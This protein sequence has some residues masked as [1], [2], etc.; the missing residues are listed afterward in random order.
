[1]TATIARALEQPLNLASAVEAAIASETRHALTL[2]LSAVMVLLYGASAPAMN[3]PLNVIAGLVLLFPMLLKQPLLWWTLVIAL[4]AGNAA[5]WYF[6]DNHKYLITYWIAACA[7]SLHFDDAHQRLRTIARLLVAVV[8]GFAV[9]W[10]L[11]GG[12][13]LNGAFLYWT[14]LTDP[15][16][17][18]LG[19]LIAGRTADEVAASSQ[20]LRV[21]ATVGADGVSLP[22]LTSGSLTIFTYVISWSVVI[23]EGIVSVLH[24][25]GSQRLYLTRHVFLIGF[26]LMTYVLLPVI[27][28]AFILTLLGF[29]QCRED[30][31]WLSRAYL[32]LFVFVQF[33][34]LPW[35]HLLPS[36]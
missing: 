16:V 23:G 26:I 3:V 31:R 19:A 2:R 8:F 9:L 5:D 24:F 25:A 20:A 27:G 13:Y 10:K 34:V 30:D 28:F 29:A 4:I 12:E 18:K 6:V 35:Q 7:L 36:D 11:I 21:L 32:A 17:Q 33:T 1:V 15:R 22:V 14:F